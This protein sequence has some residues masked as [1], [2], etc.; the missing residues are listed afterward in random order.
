MREAEFFIDALE[1]RGICTSAPWCSTRCCPA[2]FS[3]ATPPRAPASCAR[4]RRGRWRPSCRRRSAPP[5]Q[6]GPRAARDRRELPQLPGGRRARGG[7]AHRAGARPRRDR[8]RPVLRPRH[9]RPRRPAPASASASGADRMATL[10]ELAGS[11]PTSSGRSVATCSGWW[12]RGACSPTSASPTCCSSPP[13]LD[14]EDGD[15]F[16]VLAQVRPTTSQTVYRADWVG[17]TR[18]RGGAPAGRPGL[19][20][21]RD[22]RGRDHVAALRSGCGCCASPC[23]ADG[24]VIGV[25]TRESAPSFG[26]QPGELERTY[27]DVFNRFAR[28]IAAG[29]VPVR[30]RG[31]RDRGGPA[32]RRRR[33]PPRRRPAASSTPR[34]TRVS[35]LHRVGMHANAEGMRLAELGLDEA[36]SRTA[37]SIGAPVTEEVERRPDVTSCSAASRC[38]TTAPC[39]ARSCSSATSP[40]SAAATACCSP[41]TPP[42]ARSTTG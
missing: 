5:E 27:V 11:T 16:V 29:D 31:R 19:P 18:R 21:G 15:R 41:R 20:P 8:D 6:V 33:D 14:A 4:R 24:E 39:P 26:R 12:R 36:W 30:R 37:F 38:S 40:S 35:A 22:H 1:R 9:H 28:M 34:P 32:G 2:S 17:T 42:S 10:T 23:A 3:T 25:L 13:P 7:A